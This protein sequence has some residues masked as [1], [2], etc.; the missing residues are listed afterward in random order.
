MATESEL[1]RGPL[2]VLP[3][4]LPVVA[5]T[6][7]AAPIAPMHGVDGTGAATEKKDGV[8][9]TGAA[10]A[11]AG[12]AENARGAKGKDG[13]FKMGT[14]TA[15][16]EAAILRCMQISSAVIPCRF[17]IRSASSSAARAAS[18]AACTA[19]TV[20][21]SSASERARTSAASATPERCCSLGTGE[22]EE[23][24]GLEEGLELE[25]EEEGKSR[26]S[27]VEAAATEV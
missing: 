1:P 14:A 15:A 23:E 4:M 2:K 19:C 24:E 25:E 16:A 10:G 26:A 8:A 22:E 3:A 5:G 11:D 9:T 6:L 12:G 13:S 7:A 20:S 18:S 21:A 27:L 17:G